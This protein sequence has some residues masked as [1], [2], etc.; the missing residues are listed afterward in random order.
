MRGEYATRSRERGRLV[1]LERGARKGVRGKGHER[2][3]LRTLC[4][5]DVRAPSI[6]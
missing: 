3:V 1:R 6:K 4:G 5:R 2:S